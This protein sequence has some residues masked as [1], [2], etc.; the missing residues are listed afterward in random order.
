MVSSETPR[1]TAAGRALWERSVRDLVAGVRAREFTSE[2]VVEAHLER[3][4][5]AL[6]DARRAC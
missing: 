5:V 3:I 6:R 2:E 1:S 4:S